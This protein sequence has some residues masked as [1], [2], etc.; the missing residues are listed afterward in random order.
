MKNNQS[1]TWAFIATSFGFGP[2]SKAVCVAKEFKSRDPDCTVH[3]FGAGIDY[4]FAKKAQVFD[5]I[6]RFEVDKIEILRKLIPT[7]C[8]YSAVLSI[9]N[10]DLLNLWKTE[11]CPLFFIDSLAW[12]W[13]NLPEGI[14]Y[15]ST[16]FVQDYLVSRERLQQWGEKV[17]LKLVAPIEAASVLNF[18]DS[19]LREKQPRSQLLVNFSGCYNP[20]T[21][22]TFFRDYVQ[23]LTSI[24]LDAVQGRYEAIFFCCNEEM[25]DYLREKYG[26]RPGIRIGHFEHSDFLHLLASS[27]RVLSTPGITTTLEA[28]ALDIPIGFLLPQNY[29]QVL[30]SEGYSS[31]LGDQTC[32]AL[33]RFGSKFH[34]DPALPESEGVR[35]AV[36]NLALILSEHQ[37]QIRSFIDDLL[38]V[39]KEDVLT[40]LKENIHHQWDEPGQKSIAQHCLNLMEVL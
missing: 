2:I 1:S 20:Y 31:I 27:E 9:L 38:K 19:D 18:S 36:S 29:S 30:M 25:S 8:Q 4:D 5:K 28:M 14:Q 35:L 37:T 21:D 13:P 10:L 39:T 22:S 24:I 15:V 34:I 33:S 16:Y 6:F 17:N 23:I 26:T 7:L 12:M 40:R 3:F 11:Y 32:M